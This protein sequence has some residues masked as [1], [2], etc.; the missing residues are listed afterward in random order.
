MILIC[1]GCG[2]GSV[3]AGG[4][5]LTETHPPS[6]EPMDLDE[7]NMEKRTGPQED[8][9]TRVREY[10]GKQKAYQD[11]TS[12]KE[13]TTFR[14][15]LLKGAA[16]MY[17]AIQKTKLSTLCTPNLN[18]VEKKLATNLG[19]FLIRMTHECVWLTF[20]QTLSNS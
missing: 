3:A 1:L 14:E 13:N 18:G 7:E 20:E 17:S 9:M 2:E 12:A 19:S 15:S 6:R 11:G 5:Q 16:S 8:I 10:L 4:E